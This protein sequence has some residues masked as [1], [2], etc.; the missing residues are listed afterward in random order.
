MKHLTCQ[1]VT[2]DTPEILWLRKTESIYD[3]SYHL[4][5][6]MKEKDYITLDKLDDLLGFFSSAFPDET[7]G[8]SP[9]EAYD[10]PLDGIP[11]EATVEST[12]P[13]QNLPDVFLGQF[14][15]LLK[16][17]EARRLSYAS[18]SLYFLKS[19]SVGIPV[20]IKEKI[21]EKAGN[22]LSSNGDL[23]LDLHSYKEPFP[24]MKVNSLVVQTWLHFIKPRNIP[25]T[26]PF[27]KV[28]IGDD[29]PI[30]WKEFFH[31]G[32]SA[33]IVCI[34]NYPSTLEFT[35]NLLKNVRHLLLQIAG[36]E[37]KELFEV[38]VEF[39]RSKEVPLEAMIFGFQNGAEYRFLS[40]SL[41]RKLEEKKY[42]LVYVV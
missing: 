37:A 28:T 24:Y 18:K 39:L 1:N 25:K 33:A 32:I 23:V 15:F 9:E 20:C 14:C 21:V 42:E 6:R 30:E 8:L 34:N 11:S 36:P 31:P 13:L 27:L 40:G 17:L 3:I 16:P 22:Y 26:Y 29:F 2:W 12:F 5:K 10:R 19:R 4:Q 35:L 41:F 38:V 7:R